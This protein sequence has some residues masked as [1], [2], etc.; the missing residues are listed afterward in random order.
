[1]SVLHCLIRCARDLRTR[2]GFLCMLQCAACI[3]LASPAFAT[4]VLPADFDDVVY[5][6]TTIV[7]GRVVDVRSDATGPRRT[8]ESLV[9][10]AVMQTL[11]G[12]AASS[13]S[14]RLPNGQVGRYRRVV[15]GAPE[16]ASGDEVIL[17]LHGRAPAIPT[18]FGLSQGVYRVIRAAGAV[19]LVATPV[20]T[21]GIGAERIVRGDPGRRPMPVDQFIDVVRNVLG[22]AR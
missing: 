16:F 5:G 22:R 9:T 8:I 17:F 1:M 19:P 4:V 13:V 18:I 6:S 7:H 10:V 21:R 3:S 12:P 2:L 15:V 20:I 11:K 14:F